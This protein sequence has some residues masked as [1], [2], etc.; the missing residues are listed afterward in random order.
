VHRGFPRNLGGLYISAKKHGWG[1][2]DP[3]NPGQEKAT[4]RLFWSEQETC[5]GTE[6]GEQNKPL[7]GKD[8]KNSENPIVA[9]KQGN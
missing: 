3:N 4:F 7:N 1:S 2:R 8:I 9:K 5:S 6:G